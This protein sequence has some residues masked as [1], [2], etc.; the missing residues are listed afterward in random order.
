MIL[1]KLQSTP[2]YPPTSDQ[3]GTSLGGG[4]GFKVNSADREEKKSQ[5]L[6]YKY[7]SRLEIAGPLKVSTTL[8]Y[9]RKETT[10]K[11]TKIP[12]QVH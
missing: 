11:L 8:E 12:Y 1:A 2:L 7:G 3:I 4:R 6:G 10:K 5:S 9:R